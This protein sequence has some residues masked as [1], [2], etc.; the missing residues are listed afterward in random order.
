MTFNF[1]II[2]KWMSENFITLFVVI[3]IHTQLNF[4]AMGF[5]DDG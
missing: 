2:K 5:A 1:D 4:M 3:S